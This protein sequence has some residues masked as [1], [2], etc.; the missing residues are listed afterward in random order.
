MI[1]NRL[2]SDGEAFFIMSRARITAFFITSAVVLLVVMANH[3]MTWL[4][5]L[6]A[7]AAVVNAM[8]MR[9]GNSSFW[10]LVRSHPD[11]ARQWFENDPCWK[12]FYQEPPGG[13][14][15]AAPRAEW[16]GPF[17]VILLD[18]A[19]RTSADAVVFGRAKDY[20]LSQE[21]FIRMLSDRLPIQR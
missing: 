4:S 8:L 20:E 19:T 7:V 11:Y 3:W 6:V 17:R 21:K 1:V 10:R 12:V 18:R 14:R 5:I 16:A 9:S 13:Y 2:P 15:S